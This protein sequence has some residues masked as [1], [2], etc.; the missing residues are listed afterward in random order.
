VKVPSALFD[1]AI[2]PTGDGGVFFFWSQ[3]NE[4]YG[5]FARRFS[6]GGQVVGV[7]RPEAASTST[8]AW[9]APG[10]GLR[11]AGSLESAGGARIELF[12][13][14]GRRRALVRLDGAGAFDTVLPGTDRLE[15]GIYFVRA[16]FGSFTQRARVAVAR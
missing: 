11:V 4:R 9:F 5:L 13:L 2:A 8:R 7:P 1:V 12:D 15:A 3:I 10:V 16:Q 6:A 14:T